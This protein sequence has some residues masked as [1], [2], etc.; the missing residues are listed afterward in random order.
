MI[1]NHG[2]ESFLPD[3]FNWLHTKYQY[4]KHLFIQ[5]V[6]KITDNRYHKQ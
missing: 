6:H 2:Y 4:T 5:H 3:L 1:A